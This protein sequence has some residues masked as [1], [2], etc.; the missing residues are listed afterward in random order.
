M[1]IIKVNATDST[2]RHLKRLMTESALEDYTVLVAASQLKG[3]GQ[4]GTQWISE[5]GKNLTLSVL[6]YHDRFLAEHGFL[7]SMSVS[8][9]LIQLFRELQ[10]PELAIKWPNDIMSGNQKICGILIENTLK[11]ASLR[12]SI[13]GIGI[14]LNQDS[15]P[16]LPHAASLKQITGCMYSVEEVMN[17]L[18]GLLKNA[19]DGFKEDKFSDISK[20]YSGMLFRKDVK[21][22]YEIKGDS[23]MAVIKGVTLNGKLL[24][25]KEGGKQKSYDLKEISYCL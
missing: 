6:K 8:L 3:R 23:V 24:L 2:N 9:A 19:F 17:R 13:L 21:A 1:L 4:G 15:F 14:N 16:G 18:L 12:Q 20:A 5:P 22:A 7:V 10:V 25:E 11:G